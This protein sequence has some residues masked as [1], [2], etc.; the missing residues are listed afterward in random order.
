MLRYQQK[1]LIF[2]SMKA[3]RF[4]LLGALLAVGCAESVETR[5]KIKEEEV[6]MQ[7]DLVPLEKSEDPV[8]GMS[9][10]I[11]KGDTLVSV[12][13]FNKNIWWELK[14]ATEDNFMHRILY[15]TLKKPYVQIDIARR[16]AKSQEYLTGR[17]SGYH[18]LVYDALRPLSVQWE[19]WNALDTIPAFERGKFVSN[20]RNGSVHNY[21]AAVDLT[22]C[23]SKRKPLDMGAG[24][25]DI[26]KIAYP[27]LES[28]FL[29]SGEIT[30]RQIDNRKL[31]RRALK[32][33]GFS[34]IPTE[35]W[36]FNAFPRPVVKVKY[37]IVTSELADQIN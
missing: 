8:P 10:L 5:S 1:K 3:I 30:Q 37:Q 19:M 21:G 27:S 16:L 28:E 13:H 2:T 36:H 23:N 20:P 33:Q 12:D 25:D 14:Y 29:A 15:D 26:R 11:H 18:L 31:L 4:L 9:I 7:G 6:K 22:I 24:Y 17:D 34:N 32:S 35:W